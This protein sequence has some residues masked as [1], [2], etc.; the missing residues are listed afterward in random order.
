M[1]KSVTGALSVTRRVYKEASGQ[2]LQ[3]E[4]YVWARGGKKY[5][6]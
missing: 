1:F 2:Q 3:L 6:V 5:L 4:H